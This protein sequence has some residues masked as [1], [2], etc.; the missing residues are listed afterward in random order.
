MLRSSRESSAYA[1]GNT[2]EHAR[3]HDLF[4]GRCVSVS[5]DLGSG[6]EGG[7]AP[8]GGLQAE[9][10]NRITHFVRHDATDPTPPVG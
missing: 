1:W 2:R 3:R 4:V 8:R 10:S 6:G 9:Q 5:G 7:K